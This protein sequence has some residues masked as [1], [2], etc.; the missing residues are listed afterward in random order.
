[1]QIDT[2]AILAES[3]VQ[4]G[5]ARAD[6]VHP[7]LKR[8]RESLEELRPGLHDELVTSGDSEK[9]GALFKAYADRLSEIENEENDPLRYGWRVP[10]GEVIDQELERIRSRPNTIA[11]IL[12][13]GGN[14]AAKSED[15]ARRIILTMVNKPFAKVAVLC[16]SQNQAREVAMPRLWKYFPREWK[17]EES[18][19][20]K[21]GAKG[22][23]SYNNKTGFT[24]DSFTLP[25]GSSCIFKY[26][27][28]GNVKNWE[29]GE[30]DAVWADEEVTQEWVD[31]AVIRLAS[32][33]GFLIVTFTPISG[34]TPVVAWFL[35]STSVAKKRV[36]EHVDNEL[37]SVLERGNDRSVVYFWPEDNPYPLGSYKNLVQLAI[38]G[39]WTKNLIKTRLYGIPLKVKDAAFPTFDYGVHG[40]DPSPDWF[41]RLKADAK[42]GIKPTWYHVVDPCSGR[43]FFMQW[44]AVLPGLGESRAICMREWPQQEDHV[45]G[46]GDPGEWA[47]PSKDGKLKDG[48]RGP[49]Q[50]KKGFTVAFM[51]AE[52]DRIEHELAVECEGADP[53]DKTAMIQPHLRLMDSRG[54][55]VSQMAAE[56]CD[57][58]IDE[59]YK[60]R[61]DGKAGRDFEKASGQNLNPSTHRSSDG[62]HLINDFIGY[63][64]NQPIGPLNEPR[65]KFH[66]RCKNS[67]W[68]LKNFTGADGGEG[69]CKDPVDV[70]HYFVRSDP[71][72]R[73]NSP[74]IHDNGRR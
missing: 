71:Y 23:Y 60:I 1:M 50:E 47:L 15:A 25:N 51:H 38:D 42:K 56:S 30:Y 63:D 55:S 28:D 14:R 26:Y 67:M 18:G 39:K 5:L 74:W 36:A 33:S 6:E 43:P 57:T 20:Q 46:W 3:L 27:V 65:L 58:L 41:D 13:L 31:A 61:A 37:L 48:E 68:A 22:S 9:V 66:I 2:T 8:V 34:Y 40:F 29:G 7:R 53:T 35:A 69:A 11:K 21:H 49:A 64:P 45:P 12:A 73:D 16:P 24:E 32:R 4:A 72:Y 10:G 17:Q 44:Y 19:K 52:M 62:I 59:F 70:V 54:G